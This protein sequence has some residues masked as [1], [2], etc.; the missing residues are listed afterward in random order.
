MICWHKGAVPADWVVLEMTHPYSAK[1]KKLRSHFDITDVHVLS[2]AILHPCFFINMAGMT[3]LT[4]SRLETIYKHRPQQGCRVTWVAAS[5]EVPS[6]LSH[7]SH[8]ASSSSH[9]KP[10][11]SFP[12]AAGLKAKA[13]I[14]KQ[15]PIENSILLRLDLHPTGRD[16]EDWTSYWCTRRL[17]KLHPVA[18]TTPHNVSGNAVCCCA[19]FSLREGKILFIYPY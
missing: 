3:A 9:P 7:L 17:I 12:D 5:H 13:L 1:P 4:I 14:S 10:L 2:S 16:N 15:H 8:S 18:T 19:S 6:G 11:C